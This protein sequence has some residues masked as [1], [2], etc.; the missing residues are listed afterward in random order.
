MTFKSKIDRWFYAVIAGTVVFLL[1]IL[2]SVVDAL[3]TSTSIILALSFVVGAGLPLWLLASTYYVVEEG[4]LKIRSGPFNWTIRL[5]DIQS[6]EPSDSLLSSPALS[7]ER[8]KIVYGNGREILVS[9]KAK[10]AFLDALGQ[11]TN[12]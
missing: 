11:T 7:L 9:P 8:L 12:R 10:A 5:D 4:L 1:V 2:W 6:V 3:N